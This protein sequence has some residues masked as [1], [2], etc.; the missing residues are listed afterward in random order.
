[1]PCL[2]R[3]LAPAPFDPGTII[4]SQLLKE[5][6]DQIETH[7]T[8]SRAHPGLSVDIDFLIRSHPYISKEFPYLLGGFPVS[9]IGSVLY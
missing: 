6:T 1:M 2:N 7:Q 8:V 3:L 9:L 5:K 4:I